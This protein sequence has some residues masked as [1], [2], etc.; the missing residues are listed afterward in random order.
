M[1]PC[2][3]ISTIFRYKYYNKF[4]CQGSNHPIYQL[5]GFIDPPNPSFRLAYS[6]QHLPVQCLPLSFNS[7][8]SSG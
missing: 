2:D 1:E 3:Q 7:L 6:L 4:K 5:Q 8:Q